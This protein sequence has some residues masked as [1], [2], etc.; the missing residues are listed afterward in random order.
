MAKRNRR[1]QLN[2]RPAVIGLNC[3][4]LKVVTAQSDGDDEN[5]RFHGTLY[6]GG[7]LR[8]VKGYDL[9]VVLDVAGMTFARRMVANLDHD[10]KQRVGHVESAAAESGALNVKGVFSAATPARAEV[11]ESARAGFEWEASIEALPTVS[12]QI[13]ESGEQVKVNGQTFTGPLYV[14][15]KSQVRGLAF[16]SHGAD[17]GN[18]VAIAAEQEG[19]GATDNMDKDLREWIEGTLGFDAD[20]LTEEQV[21]ALEAQYNGE[22]EGGKPKKKRKRKPAPSSV[23]GVF[24][25]Q[26]RENE[27]Q[28]RLAELTESALTACPEQ[29]DAIRELA[30]EAI[31]AGWTTE[32]YELELLRKTRPQAHAPRSSR[33][34]DDGLTNQVVE[35]AVC[36]AGGLQDVENRYTDQVLQ[37]AHDR[38]P[39]GIGLQELFILGAQANG[40]RGYGTQ[41]TLDVQRAAF[42]L[43]PAG[44]VHAA[45]FSTLSIPGILS[46]T[47]N[48]FL[49]EG[50]NAVDQTW[51]TISSR[52]PV[53][54]F[55][56]VTS[57][58]LTGDFTYEKVGPTGELDHATAGEE[59]YTNKAD[60]Y[61]KM[62]SISRTD[63]INDDLGAMTAV[64]RKLGRGAALKLNNVF[65][66]VFLNNSTFF[67]AGRNNVSTGAGSALDAAGAGLAAAD[68]VFM[69]QTDPDGEPLGAMPAILLVPTTLKTTA[70]QLMD[71]EKI[72][73]DTDAADA[74]IWR[75][76]FTVAS[77][78]YMENTNYTGNSTA[79]WYLLANPLEL[80]VIQV[81]LLH[82]RDAPIVE[83]ADAA[84]NVLGVEMRGYHDFGVSLQEY[85]GGVRSAGS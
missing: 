18:Q 28:K 76:R 44:A 8:G 67:T 53:P 58:S 60:T 7:T 62:F 68:V 51:R 38:F 9:P 17:G 10:Q 50:F 12:P 54:N 30:E 85:R 81:A 59:T 42:G 66:T 40:Y 5:P 34:R 74:N 61:G 19:R 25:A 70:L 14:I 20:E 63:M 13:V 64:P 11:V 78:P 49:I 15:P 47:A 71:S 80:A 77:S 56:T 79:A 46:N 6:T 22:G 31:E 2:A 72:K 41:I 23:E 3:G 55:Q 4:E 65:W 36:V 69:N 21:E 43:T 48:K 27:R 84:F 16:V 45:G 26:E 39:H 32:T 33:R 24:A 57:Y 73:G 83:T 1:K 75:N 29:I 82:G 35:A 52:R 37:A